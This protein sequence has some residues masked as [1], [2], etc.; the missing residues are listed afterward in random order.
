[1]PVGRHRFEL[2]TK[3][4]QRDP[5]ERFILRPVDKREDLL[6]DGHTDS[7]QRPRRGS[8]MASARASIQSWVSESTFLD[9]KRP[10][11]PCF[12]NVLDFATLRVAG[13]PRQR[14]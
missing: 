6:V 14:Q 1:M 3:N 5:L 8:I 10:Y 9:R 2:M 13:R 11:L 7:R 4:L 12:A